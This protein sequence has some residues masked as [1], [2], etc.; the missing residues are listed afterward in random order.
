MQV[1]GS[2]AFKSVFVA[3]PQILGIDAVKGSELIFPVIFKTL[4]TKQYEPVR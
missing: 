2:E 1:R 3:D 4:P